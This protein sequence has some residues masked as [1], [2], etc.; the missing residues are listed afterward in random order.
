MMLRRTAMNKYF[1]FNNSYTNLPSDFYSECTPTTIQNPKILLY[2]KKLAKEIS[3][4]KDASDAEIANYLSGKIVSNDSKCISQSYC[5]H[6]FGYLNMLGDGRAVLLGEHI[7][8]NGDRLDIQLKGSGRTPYSRSGDGKANVGPMVREYIV[9]EAMH[10]LNISTT[11]SLAV[12]QTGEK[13]L[14]NKIVDGAIL[15][16]VAKSHIRVGTFEFARLSNDFHLI[17]N[18]ADYSIWRHYPEVQSDK[19]PYLSLFR[20]ILERQVKL[21]TD[22]MRVGFVHGVLNTDNVLISGETIDYGPCAFMD[23]YN[24][25]TVFSSID[26]AG[27]YSYGNQPQITIWNMYRLAETLVSLIHD[28][29]NTAM[30]MLKEELNTFENNLQNAWF[31]M[32]G[33]KLG[34]ENI[35]EKEDRELITLLLN[36]LEVY[37]FDYTNTFIYLR[38]TLKPLA[39]DA[40]KLLKVTENGMKKLN[41]WIEKWAHKLAQ[42]NQKPDKTIEI[43]ERSNPIIIPRNHLV[44]TAIQH[45]ENGDISKTKTLLNILENPYDYSFTDIH[46]MI[47]DENYKNYVTYCGT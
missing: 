38:N 12:I 28:D 18:L 32:M 41:I 40:K 26:Y 47:P 9:S 45:A 33:I 39:F 10:H 36:I 23:T 3:I 34:L 31:E 44:E 13:I 11:R 42:I 2:N 5:G 1:N 27:R 46:Y 21:V 25:N 22:W 14:R 35:R 6:Q 19:N 7:S 43:M 20:S 24:L 15:T 8:G 4:L 17:K 16:R 37:S 30:G 29:E